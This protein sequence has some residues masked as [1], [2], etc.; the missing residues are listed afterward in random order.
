[1]N[2]TAAHAVAVREFKLDRGHGYA[3]YMLFLDR[4]P[5]GVCEAKPTGTMGGDQLHKFLGGRRAGDRCLYV[6]TGRFT[7]EARFE[8]ERSSVPLTLVT[9]PSLSE[10]F[11]RHYGAPRFRGQGAGAATA[12]VLAAGVTEPKLGEVLRPL[13]GDAESILYFDDEHAWRRRAARFDVQLLIAGAPPRLRPFSV[14][15][16][17]S[18]TRSSTHVA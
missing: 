2:L 10:L 14:P 17:S 9:L 16:I 7:K 8:A 18:F 4:H 1:M 5:V 11:L 13:R 3:D 12:P 6:S 15:S